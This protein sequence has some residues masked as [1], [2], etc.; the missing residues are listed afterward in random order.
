M[1]GKGALYQK[2]IF[3]TGRRVCSSFSLRTGVCLKFARRVSVDPAEFQNRRSSHVR[4]RQCWAHRARGSE[5]FSPAETR[6]QGRVKFWSKNAS[7]RRH[8]KHV[9]GDSQP[10]R[11][12]GHLGFEP[13]TPE[14]IAP[15]RNQRS[16]A[17]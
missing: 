12:P 14:W 11:G 4:E 13:G 10:A 1:W 2:A 15:G 9:L 8:E 16:T 17:Q 6:M 3:L 5:H 7:S